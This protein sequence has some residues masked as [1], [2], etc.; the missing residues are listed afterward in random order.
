MSDTVLDIATRF[1]TRV[2]KSGNENIMAICPFHR[3]ADGSEERNPSFALNTRSGL[4]YCH[5]C[6]EGGNLRMLLD[7]AGVSRADIALHYQTAIDETAQSAPTKTSALTH[8]APTTELLDEAL[9]GLFDHCPKALLEEGYPEEL[10]RQFD[11]GF[12]LQ[13]NRVT[14]PLRDYQGRLVGISGRAVLSDARPRYK[15]YDTEY[16]DFG[17]PARTTEKRALLWNVHTVLAQA[18]FD[19][20]TCERYIVVNEG[21]KAVMRVAQAGISNVVGLLG[22]YM[23]SEQQRLLEQLAERDYAIL[24]MLD[25][26][27][28]GLNGL[29]QIGRALTKTISKV[30]V[31]SYDA[32]QPSDLAPLDIVH[33]VHT[34][35]PFVSWITAQH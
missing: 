20:A 17:L 11:V 21:F 8:I 2:H 18:A 24:L 3:K 4:W 22:S 19:V 30:F 12:D 16:L 27:D 31:V 6:H 10:L 35:Q 7:K 32:A 13:H 25:T 26:D 34:A 1:L 28:A 9:L 33:A 29:Q 23:S 15:L 14:F 5:A